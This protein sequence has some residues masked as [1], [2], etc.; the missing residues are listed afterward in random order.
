MN[1]VKNCFLVDTTLILLLL[2]VSITGLLV[3]FIFPFDSGNDELAMFF[4]TI[5]KWTSIILIVVSVYHFG[6]HWKWYK[7]VFQNLRKL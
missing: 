5:H 6:G 7:R 4:E 1:K 3:W 2:I